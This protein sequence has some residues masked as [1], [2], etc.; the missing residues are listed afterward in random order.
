MGQSETSLGRQQYAA[1]PENDNEKKQCE[2]SV[3]FIKII[4]TIIIM[5]LQFLL[6]N[7]I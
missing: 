6:L 5:I 7:V 1:F 4:I 3:Y 2:D